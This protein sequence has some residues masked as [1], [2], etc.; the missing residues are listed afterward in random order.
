MKCTWQE[1][2]RITLL[3]NGDNFYPAV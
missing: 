2:N 3:E 1:G